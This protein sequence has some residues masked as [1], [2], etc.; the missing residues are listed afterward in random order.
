MTSVFSVSPH[1]IIWAA[2]LVPGPATVVVKLPDRTIRDRVVLA[3]TEPHGVV[4]VVFASGGVLT[5]S[6]RSAVGI[7]EPKPRSARRRAS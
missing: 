7:I 1:R 2:D 4:R 5:L 6:T 3:A